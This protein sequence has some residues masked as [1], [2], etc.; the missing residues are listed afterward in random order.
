MPGE[1]DASCHR[2]WWLRSCATS[3]GR[4]EEAGD[5]ATMGGVPAASTTIAPTSR[6][7]ARG[8]DGARTLEHTGLFGA[9]ACE[10]RASRTRGADARLGRPAEA[11]VETAAPPRNR[12]SPAGGSTRGPLLPRT[13]CDSADRSRADACF[14][15][16]EQAPRGAGVDG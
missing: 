9:P 14:V 12:Q 1:R 13:T 4:V 6:T 11:Q 10:K 15:L 7:D 8:R 16:S 2:L 5:R 3:R